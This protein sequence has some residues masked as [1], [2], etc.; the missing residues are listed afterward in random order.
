MLDE[1]KSAPLVLISTATASTEEDK[2]HGNAWFRLGTVRACLHQWG[3]AV[4]I[5]EQALAV[6][7]LTAGNEAAAR[8]NLRVAKDGRRCPSPAP[9]ASRS[10]RAR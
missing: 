8:D 3:E 1:E 9:P 7:G 10:R 6:G 5:L 2:T 4:Q